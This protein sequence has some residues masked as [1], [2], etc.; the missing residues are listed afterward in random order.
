MELYKYNYY[1]DLRLVYAAG[2][3]CREEVN[4]SRVVLLLQLYAVRHTTC[5]RQV[6]AA[7]VSQHGKGP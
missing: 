3:N 4:T 2:G 5:R 7:Q 6:I 1:S